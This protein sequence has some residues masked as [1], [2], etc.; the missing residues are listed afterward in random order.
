MPNLLSGK[1]KVLAP[2][3]LTVDRYNYI[4][5]NQS[6]PSLGRPTVDK[7][8]LV[9]NLD[10]TTTWV[11]QSAIT[12]K[13]LALKNMIFVA[14]NG[15]DSN[16]GASVSTPKQSLSGA[17][18]AASAGTIILVFAG[19]YTENNPLVVPEG[20]SI[21]GYDSK[22]VVV[23]KNPTV[24]VF[25]L[26]SGT[27]I[28]NIVVQDHKA[29]SYAFSLYSNI[30]I[31]ES[32]KII[33][34]ESISGPYLN[35]G[36]LFI[37]YV[38]VQN[39][40]ISPRKMPLMN[41]DVPDV[42]K[43]VNPNGAGGGIYID[44]NNIASNSYSRT[45]FIENF[46]AFN[47]GGV[48]IL[49]EN[50]VSVQ[51]DSSVTKFCSVGF[52]T[53]NGATMTLNSCTTEYGTLGLVA[54]NFSNTPYLNDGIVAQSLFSYINSVSILVPGEGYTSAPDVAFGIEWQSGQT[55]TF[56]SQIFYG[57]NLYLVTTQGALGLTPPTH[58]SGSAT[59]GSAELLYTGS[60]AVGYT[61]INN[62]AVNSIVI[63][64]QGS[65]YVTEPPVVFTGGGYTTIA[66]ASV[67]ISGVSEI[68][69]GSLTQAPIPGSIVNFGNS[70]TYYTVTYVTPV[71]GNLSDI[72]IYP[73]I[74][75]IF[76]GLLADFYFNSTILANGHTFRYVGSGT[77]YN[78]LPENG[79]VPLLDNEI[80]Q[81]NYGKI[82]YSSVNQSGNYKI[83]DVFSVD[84]ITNTT[85][86]NAETFNL[87]N[88]GAI[89]PLIRDGVP[90]GV[91]MKEI[92]NDTSLLASTGSQDPFTV[93]TQYAVATYLNNNYVPLNGN[94]TIIG[95]ITINDLILSG[96]SIL[97]KNTNQ[98]IVLNPNGTGSIN[99]SSSRIINV[100]DPI[101]GQDAA[102]KA[103]VDNIFSGGT[104]Y[105]SQY[106]GDFYIHQDII[107]NVIPNGDMQLTT[108]GTGNVIV[109][110]DLD[111]Y[112]TSSGAFV[113]N[114]GVGIGK[115]LYVGTEV[116]AP[117][118]YGDLS[119][120]ASSAL[121][122]TQSNQ[123]AITSVGTLTSLQ[124][125]QVNINNNVIKNTVLDADLFL[126]VTGFGDILP[127]ATNAINFGSIDYTWNYGYFNDIF[128][129][130]AT[131]SQPNI[132]GLGPNVTIYDPSILLT[133]SLSIG[134]N[135][136][137]RLLIETP[138]L[139]SN[140]YDTIF[141]TKSSDPSYGKII[142]NPKNTLSLTV[143]DS[144][145][146]VTT[147][148]YVENA[149]HLIQPIVNL[150]S[151]STTNISAHDTGFEYV[152]NID[153]SSYIV[154]ILLTS[155]GM[156]NT[157]EITLNDTVNN[158]G[159]ILGDFLAFTGSFIPA[160]LDQTWE[161]ISAVSGGTSV[162]L[163]VTPQ[164]PIGQYLLTPPAVL[165][166]KK[167]FFGYKQSLDA[168][169]IIPN[170]TITNNV[171]T[172][173]VG[174][175][176]ANI[177]SSQVSITGG[178]IDNTTIGANIPA[179]ATFSMV[180][181]NRYNTTI[182]VP[183][184]GMVQTAIDTFPCACT[185]IAKYIVKVKRT[186]VTPPWVSGQDMLIVQ[187]GID[188]YITEYG[189][190]YTDEIMGS[191]TATIDA[192]TSLVS[193]WFTPAYDGVFELT[194]FRFYA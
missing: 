66:E 43:R 31:K 26:S 85:T 152:S 51:V 194:L 42:N 75:Y 106:I 13:T 59:N 104:S 172:G 10:G 140:L 166:S 118:F 17:L 25:E 124:V 33:N 93:P 92:S 115:K 40:N 44:G 61:T 36:T 98:N 148:L 15:N 108:T 2:S 23:P 70:P 103:Y 141:T 16:D 29:P 144:G 157:T 191:F 11:A 99:A 126:G 96:N 122:V 77:T 101:S 109:T 192:Q 154:S 81:T 114:G 175:I 21:V 187:D 161:V 165:L 65:G 111:S 50:N 22:I 169:T 135:D 100:T 125:D 151:E 4:S 131:A 94:S 20:V 86:L 53:N 174:T 32:P 72:K 160:G 138:S 67:S 55:A 182:K 178:A 159:I 91:Q 130:L 123:S 48:G 173:D 6:Q 41:A 19:V 145:V 193:L 73:N 54:S 177:E 143:D 12:S 170:A 119:G 162:L 95:D 64:D 7:S 168:L 87:A 1:V 181:S 5:L 116:H 189:I 52:K 14:T 105:Q 180:Y 34:C 158:V 45:V 171:V 147:P 110:S 37:P 150:G 8:I 18:S 167:G 179:N 89:G 80:V 35:D 82:Y 63:T 27:A 107:E 38:T 188:I 186:D 134:F 136:N 79:G 133:P 117:T 155:D 185:D 190:E 129:T 76:Q 57:S 74:K 112:S 183:I 127:E 58:T 128:G 71:V 97:S 156:T 3:Q 149:L 142:F 62:G 47:Q 146:I 90:S 24:N 176:N 184:T 60:V 120:L 28:E 49:A 113:V 88:L 137:N 39:T 132:S 153:I 68:P 78:A 9:G 102:T 163:N 139:G 121:I 46:V 56:Y 83:G 30:T 164:L 69:I 84:L